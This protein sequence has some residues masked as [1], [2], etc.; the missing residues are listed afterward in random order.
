[1]LPRPDWRLIVRDCPQ[2]DVPTLAQVCAGRQMR[3]CFAHSGYWS[4]KGRDRY[5]R[6]RGVQTLIDADTLPQAQVNSWG[7]SDRAMYQASLDWI[8][9]DRDRPFF[10]LAY[11]IE[12]HHPY[13]SPAEPVQFDTDDAELNR[14]LNAVRAA[15]AH[16]GW[17]VEQLR[18]RGLAEST[19]IAITSDHGECFGQHGQRVHSFGLYEPE[20]HVPLVLLNP[21]LEC[22]R[23]DDRL[24][25]HLDL[26]ATLA[27]LMGFDLPSVWQGVDLSR[28]PAKAR[29]YFF[30]TGHEIVLGLRDGRYKYHYYV[31]TGREELFDLQSDPGETCNLAADQPQ[32]A[33]E[34]RRRVGG[35]VEYQRR[36]LA[37][38]GA[39]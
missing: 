2:F 33:A 7:V 21:H 5:L 38:H 24:C 17:L 39:E 22:P 37:Q 35:M 8:D 1:V 34:Y 36:F 3:T 9:Q 10:L 11:T 27:G 20:V 14:Y 23:R 32:R 28:Q 12:T 31:D 18:V 6:D 29:A 30:S 16:I 19:L 26:P 13:V 4:W 25:Q 15:D